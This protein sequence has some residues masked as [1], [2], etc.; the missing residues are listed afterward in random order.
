[1]RT[2]DQDEEEADP[3][4]HT[5]MINLLFAKEGQTVETVS[6]FDGAE[7][8]VCMHTVCKCMFVNAPEC[9]R[10]SDKA[11]ECMVHVCRPSGRRWRSQRQSLGLR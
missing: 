5:P 1:M 3:A 4:E 10:M 8:K 9:L 6:N 2:Q 11:C 7:A